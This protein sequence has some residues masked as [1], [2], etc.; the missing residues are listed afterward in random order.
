MPPRIASGHIRYGQVPSDTT[1]ECAGC[2]RE[3][4]PSR[5]QLWHQQ[6]V[7][8]SER[9]MRP[10]CCSRACAASSAV[11][12]GQEARAARYETMRRRLA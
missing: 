7:W 8:Y 10:L 11:R 5:K 6:A 2:G 3:F 12:R 9:R 1:D 4:T